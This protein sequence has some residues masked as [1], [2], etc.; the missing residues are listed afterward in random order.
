MAVVAVPLLEWVYRA[1]VSR[2]L[3]F[4]APTASR[5]SLARLNA[6]L[7]LDHIQLATLRKM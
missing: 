4:S 5:F 1:L 2:L 7:A 3:I 6:Q